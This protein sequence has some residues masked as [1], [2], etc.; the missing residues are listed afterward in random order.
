MRL[1]ALL[2]VILVGASGQSSQTDDPKQLLLEVRK[3]VMLTIDRLPKYMCTETVERVTFL[4]KESPTGSSCDDLTSRRRQKDSTRVRKYTA[5]RLRLNVAISSDGEIYSWA[6]ENRFQDKSLANLVNGGATSTGA[7]AAFL[8]SIFQSNA[9]SFTFNGHMLEGGSRLA[10]YGFRVPLDK[11]QY[12]IGNG[13]VHDTVAYDGT[14]LVDPDTFNLVRLNVRADQLPPDLRVCDDTTALEYSLV[15][16]HGSEFLLPSKVH[17]HIV[18]TSGSE[19]QNDT[20]F[21]GCREFRGESSLS[22]SAPAHEQAEVHASQVK[23]LTLPPRL[24]FTIALSRAISIKDSAAGDA[25]LATLVSPLRKRHGT[26]LLPK[27]AM[28]AGRILRLERIYGPSETLKLA[29]RFETVEVNGVRQ[30]FY[31]TLD[32]KI[33]KRTRIPQAGPGESVRVRQELGTF[34]ELVDSSDPGVGIIEFDDVTEDYVIQR[35]ME[36]SGTTT[37]PK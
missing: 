13:E 11:S 16:L 17:W 29:I 19:L 4:P 18:N 25:I 2:S 34:G 3:K 5:D 26:I 21:S 14:F 28:L 35:G 30:P 15:R 10:E 37:A 31:A 33:K 22:F 32:S 9:A 6:G 8:R 7:F 20:V 27:G 23:T 12:T 24:P 36:I 1:L